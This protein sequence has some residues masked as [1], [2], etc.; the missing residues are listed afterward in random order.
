M[1]SY[2][3]N[4]QSVT[5]FF[6]KTKNAQNVYL[7]KFYIKKK[8]IKPNL[9]V[10]FS[11]NKKDS[12]SWESREGAKTYQATLVERMYKN[13]IHSWVIKWVAHHG[14]SGT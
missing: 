4:I 8:I 1:W 2:S 5:K 11:N 14:S 13:R 12:V 3:S 9:T 7:F 6:L 10:E